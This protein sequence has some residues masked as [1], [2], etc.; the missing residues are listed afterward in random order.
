MNSRAI[1]TN[2]GRNLPVEE[3][4]GS[5]F[6]RA[7]RDRSSMIVSKRFCYAY[8][9]SHALMTA[10]PCWCHDVFMPWWPRTLRFSSLLIPRLQPCCPILFSYCLVSSLISL[11]SYRSLISFLVS[12][13]SILFITIIV[14]SIPSFLL[15]AI[16][17]YRSS[18]VI[19]LPILPL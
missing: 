15:L 17:Q 18:A 16:E 12:Y 11:F 4:T 2:R 6:E 3:L 13:I 14:I 9:I 7:N 10:M 8:D 5:G 19:P 1:T